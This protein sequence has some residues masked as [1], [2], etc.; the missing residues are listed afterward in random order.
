[1]AYKL[2]EMTKINFKKDI[3]P[4]I[5][6]IAVFYIITLLFFSPVI[7]GGKSISQHDIQ[8]HLGS[9][10]LSNEF[11]DATGE[12][13]LW[14]NSMFSG[15]PSYLVGIRYSGDLI[16][17]VHNGLSLG[18]PHPVRLIFLSFLCFYILLISFGVRPLISIIGAVGWGL[19][20]YLLISISAGH[21]GK[22]GAIAYLP[23]VIA[24]IHLVFTDRK[25]IGF[26]LTALALALH[27]RL[28]HFQITYYLLLI[29]LAY[30]LLQLIDFAKK[31]EIKKFFTIVG[32][33]S[34]A[35]L[36]AAGANAGKILTTLEYG[37]YSTR[38]NRELAKESEANTGLTKDYAFEFSNDIMEPLFLF[39]P[40]IFGGSSFEVLADDRK[41][42]TAK[43]IRRIQ[44]PNSRQQLRQFTRA[45]WGKQRLSAPYYAGAISIFAMVIGFFFVEKK[46]KIWL[47][48]L[49]VFSIMLTWGSNFSSFNYFL[50][51]YLPG[52]NKFRSVTFAI[53]IALFGINLLGFLGLEKLLASNKEVKINKKFYFAAGTTLGVAF[54]VL[55][56]GGFAS[57]KGAYDDQLPANFFEALRADRLSLLRADAFRSLMFVLTS[58]IILWFVLRNKLSTLI[59]LSIIIGLVGFDMFTASKRY[60]PTSSFQ[61]NTT[62]STIKKSPADE[63]ILNDPSKHYRVANLL[64]TFAEANTSYFHNSIGG[65]HG[66]KLGR[67][68][69]LIENALSPEING[70]I[71]QLQSGSF[72]F[73]QHPVL[74]MLN[75]KY[76]KYGDD[77]RAVSINTNALGNAWL[78]KDIQVV[79]S[80]REEMD[81]VLS[82]ELST[83]AIINSNDSPEDFSA[84]IPDNSGTIELTSHQPNE[85]IY[86][87]KSPQNSGQKLAVFSEIYYPKG[88]VAYIDGKETPILRAN[89]LLR[90][91][92]L[93]GGNHEIKFKF[94]SASYNT[95]NL[96][97]MI[98]SS[99]IL[100]GVISLFIKN[101]L[102]YKKSLANG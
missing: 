43:F 72:N 48:G 85:L 26:I 38:G 21:N 80:A 22:V 30:G 82:K 37:K 45:Y 15:M 36:L 39:I 46:Y 25:W 51:D 77:A 11:R 94:S 9:T 74:D 89:Y 52:Y 93:P 49:I 2:N 5:I 78:V 33:L 63:R 92:S 29:V 20:T 100:I 27:L 66:A 81:A 35:A 32:F 58:A 34:V 13:P 70:I 96:M 79:S 59:G 1:M 42:E 88:W 84:T 41:N 50:F 99:L 24:G 6:A 97:M 64:G 87:L 90:A 57:F 3:L 73:G 98:F 76:F 47:G 10:Q 4:H 55:I 14:S 23:L 68:Q 44:D 75:A 91:I 71:S 12:E 65:Y 19:N 83:V 62:Q 16:K 7:F 8:Q 56:F 61:K 31:K 95:G 67:Y 69:D 101:F 18:L 102:A 17:Y 54:L 53:I 40:N 60:F 86:Q 28:N